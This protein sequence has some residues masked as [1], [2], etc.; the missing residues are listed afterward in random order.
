MDDNSGYYYRVAAALLVATIAA[1]DLLLLFVWGR[2]ATISAIVS[3]WF[4]RLPFLPYW[5]AFGDGALLYHLVFYCRT[6]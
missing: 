5:F 1:I 4:Q 3:Q 2:D 6:R